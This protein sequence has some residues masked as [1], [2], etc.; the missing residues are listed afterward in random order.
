MLKTIGILLVICGASGT[1]FSMAWNVRQT[2]ALVQQLLAA[3]ELMKNEIA[4]RRTPLPEL[5]RLLEVQSRGAAADLFGRLAQDFSQRQDRTVDAIVRRQ[6]MATRG[7]PPAVRQILL[8]LG[9]GL[10]QYDKEGQLRSI[11]LAVVRLR[12][13][14]E[15]YRD[16]QQA[17]IRS[18]CTLGICGGL[19]IAIMAL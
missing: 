19:A 7:F 18:Y 14:L 6:V 9:S 4:Y 15:Q 1:G 16:E 17:R 8:Q 3:L 10:G 2:V 11:D 5:M 12:S 13:L